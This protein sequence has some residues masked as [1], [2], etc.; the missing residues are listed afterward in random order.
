MREQEIV[1]RYR[2]PS[3]PLEVDEGEKRLMEEAQRNFA[4][5]IITLA[6]GRM[7]DNGVEFVSA[8]KKEGYELAADYLGGRNYGV[9]SLPEFLKTANGEKGTVTEKQQKR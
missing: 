8:R 9:I 3:I 5:Q 2:M 1:I 4:G 6:M 7:E